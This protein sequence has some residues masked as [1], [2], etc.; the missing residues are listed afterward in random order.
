MIIYFFGIFKI[1][2]A[3]VVVSNFSISAQSK[4]Y[5]SG[6]GG[7][8][9]L[10]MKSFSHFLNLLPNNKVDDI[11]FNGEFGLRF[12]FNARH[13][14]NLAIGIINKNASFN[15]GFGGANWNIR[16]FPISMGY[17]FGFGNEEKNKVLTL[18]GLNL[19]YNFIQIDE[20]SYSDLGGHNPNNFFK[21]N[22]FAVEPNIIMIYRLYDDL[23]LISKVGYRYMDDVELWFQDLNLSGI[24]INVGLQIKLFN[25][26]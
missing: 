21:M 1:F 20:K 25:S 19:S 24:V 18:I 5:L 23:G 10:P 7:F 11:G 14:A 2:L 3:F 6:S 26:I 8:N 4:I 13:N 9:Y 12:I 15:S 22:R 17:N 16:I